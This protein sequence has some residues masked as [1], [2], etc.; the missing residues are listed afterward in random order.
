M[1]ITRNVHQDVIRVYVCM[2][3]AQCGAY[4]FLI[5]K[6]VNMKRYAMVKPQVH[7]LLYLYGMLDGVI[8]MQCEYIT[9]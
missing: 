9:S 4:C 5:V 2:H 7:R 3:I 6:K 8:R 1:E